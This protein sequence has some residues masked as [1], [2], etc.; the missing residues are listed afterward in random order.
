MND[1]VL[2][3]EEEGVKDGV[4]VS[5]QWT[6]EMVILFTDI[7]NIRRDSDLVGQSEFRFDHVDF[8]VL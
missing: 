5:V 7:D 1:W 4:Q 2:G 8:E 6:G 3:E